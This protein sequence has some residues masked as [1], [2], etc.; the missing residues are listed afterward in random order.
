MLTIALAQLKG[1][2]FETTFNLNRVLSMIEQSKEKNIDYILFPELF[3]SG[4][5]IQ[6]KVKELAEPV[7]GTSIRAIQHKVKET[8][9]GVIIG[10]PEYENNCYYNSAAFIEKDGSLKGVYRKTHLFDK[11][12][13]FFTPGEEFPIFHTS[14]GNIALMMTFDVEFP[15]VSRI[16]A[17][18]GADLLLVLNAHSVPYEPHQE[19]FLRARALENQLFLAAANKVG[20]E[21]TTLFFGE[22]AVISPEGH[23]IAK[24]G[25]N[26]EMIV[27]SIDL[28]D[29]HKTREE[30]PMKYLTNR[31]GQLYTSYFNSP[32]AIK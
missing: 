27:A 11:E 4:F 8:G 18:E 30:Q 31:R 17:V 14:F 5:L 2:L 1:V 28:S 6:D 15:E 9:V 21:K 22:S 23:F 24:A 7:N 12:K 20:L 13:Q 3:L 25:N 16:Y 32:H 19:L 26:E 29:I 10:F